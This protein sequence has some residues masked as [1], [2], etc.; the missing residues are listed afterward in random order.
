MLSSQKTVVRQRSDS[1]SRKVRFAQF[2]K[3]LTEPKTVYILE[4]GKVSACA[5]GGS[6]S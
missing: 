5:T 4:D 6:S 2:R 1:L 3:N